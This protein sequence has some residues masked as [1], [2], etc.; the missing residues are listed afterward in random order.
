MKLMNCRVDSVF[1]FHYVAIDTEAGVTPAAFESFVR[2][3]G[4]Y[5][6]TYPGWSWTLLRG[7]RGER[8]G[9][10]LMLCEVD[11][12]A[13][14][15]RYITEDGNKT[16]LAREFWEQHPKATQILAEWKR[17]GT[18]CELPT[19]YT[20]YRLLAENTR[21]S[22]PQGPRFQEPT[23][24]DPSAR[25]IGIH[26]L[27]LRPDVRAETFE[28]FVAQNHHRIEDYPNWKFRLLKGERGNRLDQYVVMMEIASLTALDV[29]YPEADIAT[30][31]AAIFAHSHRDTKLMYEEWKQ[32]ASFSG[33]PQIYTDY[34]AV[35][36]SIN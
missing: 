13:Q 25:V 11:N 15:D 36:Q 5:M 23:R 34:I 20:D 30:E 2:H 7:L 16:V 29:F 3:C 31:E 22:L 14:R 32:L 28:Q 33:S 26:N 19:L 17:Y 1:S 24:G 4:V 9:Q 27:A 10:Y 18:F 6:P 35:A 12:A 21:S 8:V